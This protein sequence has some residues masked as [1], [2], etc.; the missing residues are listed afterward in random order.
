MKPIDFRNASLASLQ[1]NIGGARAVT[2][3]AW[4][5]HGPC[6]TQQLAGR[7]G[8]SILSLRPRTTELFQLGFICLGENQNSPGEGTYRARTEAELLRWFDAQQRAATPM[9]PELALR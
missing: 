7:S 9:Q 1:R 4:L 5:Q 3:G 2:L 6:T 8:L